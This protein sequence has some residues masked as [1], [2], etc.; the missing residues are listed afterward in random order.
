MKISFLLSLL[1]SLHIVYGLSV[2]IDSTIY[3]YTLNA[4]KTNKFDRVSKYLIKDSQ[5]QR[6]VVK[7]IYYW[8]AQNISYDLALKSKHDIT[9][10]DISIERTLQ[11]RMTI[12]SG[13]S[14]LLKA[15]CAYAG[16]ECK[17]INGRSKQYGKDI[18]LHS[19][20]KVKIHRKWYLIDS[21]WGSGYVNKESGYVPRLNMQY[22][23][24]NPTELIID[25]FPDS[26]SFQ[27]LS[28]P[29]TYDEFLSESFE[30]LRS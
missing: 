18:E 14:K 24:A 22:L 28:D 15:F 17:I 30:D 8:I 10:E 26:L 11:N 13:Y 29:I 12:C 4:P 16:I 5:N 27:L 25:H 6:E 19:W 3:N 1:F 21:T 2:M 20:N 9:A 23:F 7:R